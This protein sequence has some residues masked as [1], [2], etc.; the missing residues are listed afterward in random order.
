MTY[1]NSLDLLEE[2]IDTTLK[3]RYDKSDRWDNGYRAGLG[4]VKIW[5]KHQKVK[6]K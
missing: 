5:I 6:V 4:Q 3:E 1:V 2:M